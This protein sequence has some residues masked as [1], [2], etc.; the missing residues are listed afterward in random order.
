M[1]P[2]SCPQYKRVANL[3]ASR[4]MRVQAS[5]PAAVCGANELIIVVFYLATVYSTESAS[6]DRASLEIRGTVATLGWND[7]RLSPRN[8]PPRVPNEVP[9]VV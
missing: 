3:V 2:E 4:H 1:T 8:I 7:Y 6:T 5:R 9:W